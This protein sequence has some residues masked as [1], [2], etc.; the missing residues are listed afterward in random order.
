MARKALLGILA[1][2]A[3]AQAGCAAG[4][5]LVMDAAE[6]GVY[7]R[8][9]AS[10]T[11]ED[12][13]S[14]SQEYLTKYP[15]GVYAAD[16]R[17]FFK[18]AE[19]LYFAEA[20]TS[21]AGLEAYLRA[22]PH[23]PS[24]GEATMRLRDLRALRKAESTDLAGAAAATDA[25]VVREAERRKAVR[26]RIEQWLGLFLD[27]GTFAA[28]MIDAKASLI[29]PW[30]LALPWPICERTEPGPDAPPYPKGAARRCA[31]LLQLDYRATEEGEAQERQ[32]L[33]EIAVWQDEAGRPL[34]VTIGGPELFLRLDETVTARGAVATDPEAK[35]RGAERAVEIAQKVFGERVGADP[36]CKKASDSDVLRLACKGVELRVLAGALDGEDDRFV[37]R[38]AP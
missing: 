37:V 6:Y 4:R 1:L 17:A 31:K 5:P 35:L 32:A 18:G 3:V 20:K 9:R 33:V 13:L 14:A 16:V 22:M 7:R 11:I 24:A 15:D 19:P 21:I 29:V 10:T 36:S 12:R 2:L 8:A 28:P 27:A 25:A 34:E 38:S 30:S 23:G 26:D